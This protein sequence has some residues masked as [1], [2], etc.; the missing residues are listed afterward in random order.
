MGV[1]SR[2]LFALHSKTNRN[3]L[4]LKTIVPYPLAS[5]RQQTLSHPLPR[6]PN[7]KKKARQIPQ[8]AHLEIWDKETVRVDAGADRVVSL[9]HCGSVSAAICSSWLR[10]C[11]SQGAVPF[12]ANRSKVLREDRSCSD[13]RSLR[14]PDRRDILVPAVN[15]FTAG[16]MR[17]FVWPAGALVRIGARTIV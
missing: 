14:E 11:W 12:S 17:T 4:L 10:S 2:M 1:K 6:V 8:N 15:L 3:I 16:V 7:M 9:I 13:A 5:G